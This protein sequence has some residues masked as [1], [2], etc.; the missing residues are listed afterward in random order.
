[1]K[2]EGDAIH[3]RGGAARGW[4]GHTGGPAAAA[5]DGR[6]GEYPA[7]AGHG[8]PGDEGDFLTSKKKEILIILIHFKSL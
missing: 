1:M 7:A 5:G 3:L 8:A 4:P 6:R 2:S